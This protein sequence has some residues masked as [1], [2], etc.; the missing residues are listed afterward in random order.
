MKTITTIKEL[1][2]TT[3]RWCC[4]KKSI[5]LVP[6]MGAL[7]EGHLSLIKAAKQ[8]CDRVVVSIFVNPIQFSANEDFANYPRE[9]KK[10]TKLLMS[11]K[12]DALF[13]PENET[14]YPP[15]F[16][17]KVALPEALCR[18]LCG[19]SRPG[20]FEGVATVVTKLFNLVRPHQAYFGQKDYQQFKIVQ[21]VNEDLNCGVQLNLLP[22]VRETDGLAKSSRNAYLS[23]SERLAA[24]ALY[25]ALKLADGMLQVGERNPAALIEAITK[26][27][28][29]EPCIEIEY[30]AAK[31]A[32]TLEDLNILTGK[33]LVAIAV[34]I[35]QTRLIDNIV[36]EV[37]SGS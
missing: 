31:D 14:M 1:R 16:T 36:V 7:H 10:D 27:L 25:R 26:N 21:R 18:P 4:N 30:I 12:I 2:T 20:H 32:S 8:A 3:Q 29:S 23:S 24:P 13:L 11:E 15:A 6:T 22:T 9:L 34:K 17:T 33:V 28:S 37:D 5:G 19:Q 35:G